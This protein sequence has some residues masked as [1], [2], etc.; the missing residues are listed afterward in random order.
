MADSLTTRPSLLVRIR[1]PRDGAA[2][3]EFVDLYAPL[4]FG[5]ARKQGLQNADAADLTQEVLR[6][7][8]GAAGR[9][10]Y[11][12]ERGTFRGWL[13]TV[14][15]NRLRN[16]LIARRRRERGGDPE[17]G[18]RLEDYPAP[19][20]EA[21]AVWD[22]EYEQRLF[23]WAAE[24][25][26]RGCQESTWRAFWLTAVEGWS[27]KEAARAVGLTPAAVYLAKRRVMARLQDQLRQVQ[28]D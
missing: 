14:V 24:Q 6:A 22:R 21:S 26:R 8:A 5:F 28:G 27:G 10:R 16:F 2:W 1:D 3:T 23:A 7:V 11:D 25:V 13:F 12:P 18:R 17:A 20:D 4:I 9:L 15:R 19:E